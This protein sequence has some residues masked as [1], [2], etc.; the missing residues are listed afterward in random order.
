MNRER[1]IAR[2]LDPTHLGEV[3][4]WADKIYA[5]FPCLPVWSVG[6]FFS[7]VLQVGQAVPRFAVPDDAW[8]FTLTHLKVTHQS[9]TL[10][11]ATTIT[12][13]R[14]RKGVTKLLGTSTL[15]STSVVDTLYSVEL[16]RPEELEPDDLIKWDCTAIGGHAAV[17]AYV[18][19]RQ[20]S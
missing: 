16:A 3:K 5:R 6:A 9:G 10:T 17:T 12:V 4:L 11:A 2:L 13:T 19:G 14:I 8:G 18:Q 7:G 20:R 15:G 1:A